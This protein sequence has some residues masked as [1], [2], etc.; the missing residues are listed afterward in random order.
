[1]NI[2]SRYIVREHIGPFFLS[3]FIITGVLL[4]NQIIKLM[5]L[6]FVKGLPL[7][8]ILEV[9]LLSLCFL[10]V[11]SVP[12]A[13]LVATI[14]AFG[15]LSE[16]HEITAMKANGISIYSLLS[17]ILIASSILAVLLVL[18]NN[19]VLPETN[20]RLK[21]LM[22]DIGR[23][24]P[25]ITIQEGIFID[26]FKGFRLLIDQVDDRT[27]RLYG[28]KIIDHREEDSPK[29]IV[30]E[31]G[32]IYSPE[33]R[34]LFVI[35]LENGLITEVDSEDPSEFRRLEFQKYTL[36]LPIDDKFSRNERSYR[37]DREKSTGMMLDDIE[38]MESSIVRYRD[39]L[40]EY[41]LPDSEERFPDQERNIKRLKSLIRGKSTQIDRLQVEIHKKF[42]ISI[43][44]ICF[45][46][47]GAPLGAIPK[48][49]GTGLSLG[50]ALVLFLIYYLCL[51]GGEDLADRGIVPAFW[52]MWSPNILITIIGAYLIVYSTHDQIMITRQKVANRFP[53]LRVL[54][55]RPSRRR[56]KGENEEDTRERMG[57]GR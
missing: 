57:K 12:M 4:L 43:A 45:I 14:M 47:I 24:R 55:T 32:E 22:S 51:I 28:V 3:L 33:D 5:E 23:K 37:G 1:M 46:L 41:E 34:D 52:A 20:H 38:K 7:L 31:E 49:G 30:A 27:N 44:C 54:L 2:L 56:K 40:E 48:K 10:I 18:F 26:D 29:T 35:Q 19:H 11:M 6:I 53:L 8:I 13:V 17:P 25:T 21:N 15:R 42:A 50:I 16:D 9:F 39:E 36:N